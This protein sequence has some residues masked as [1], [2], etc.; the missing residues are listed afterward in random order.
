MHVDRRPQCKGGQVVVR[1]PGQ[2]NPHFQPFKSEFLSRNLDK[3]LLKNA[4][5][6]EKVVKSATTSGDPPPNP[7]WPPAAESSA[8]K[9]PH[10]TY[11]LLL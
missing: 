9:P 5:F 4:Y 7:R 1:A 6:L 2:T 11:H 10:Y 3:N 8:P